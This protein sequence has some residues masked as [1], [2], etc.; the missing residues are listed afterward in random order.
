MT[1]NERRPQKIKSR[2]SQKPLVRSYSNLKLKLMSSNQS[3][4]RYEMKMTYNGRRSQ[5]EDD[6]KI[7][8]IKYISNHWS[9]LTKI[10][11]LS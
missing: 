6:L 4:Q 3:V 2:I 1:Y 5:E 7:C 11:N 9:D 10:W 8:E